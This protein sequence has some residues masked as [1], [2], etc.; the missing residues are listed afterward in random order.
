MRPQS[1]ECVGGKNERSCRVVASLLLSP[2]T[3]RVAP[4]IAVNSSDGMLA[5]STCGYLVHCIQLV[6]ATSSTFARMHLQ[7]ILKLPSRAVLLQWMRSSSSKAASLLAVA[8][9]GTSWLVDMRGIDTIASSAKRM[10]QELVCDPMKMNIEMR[11]PIVRPVGNDD[12]MPMAVTGLVEAAHATHAGLL[13]VYGGTR[14]QLVP[15][16][17][18]GL[19]AQASVGAAT[20]E[21]ASPAVA[22]S[23]GSTR[24]VRAFGVSNSSCVRGEIGPSLF[25]GAIH[26][27]QSALF[28]ATAG[29]VQHAVFYL[30]ES[31]MLR[32]ISSSPKVRLCHVSRRK[33]LMLKATTAARL[34]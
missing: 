30:E 15:W 9:D 25:R 34:H 10:R 5:V 12:R 19:T 29:G 26:K 13:V 28:H 17:A 8:T 21:S 31:G 14:A 7:Y 3:P 16:P 33:E 23:V 1:H 22:L 4:I 27:L 18:S 24:L 11:R 2:L 20:T 32:S 6:P